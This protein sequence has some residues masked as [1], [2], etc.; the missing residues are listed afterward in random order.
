MHIGTLHL[1][2]RYN[3]AQHNT[4]RFHFGRHIVWFFP[5]GSWRWICGKT[6]L[7]LFVIRVVHGCRLSPCTIMYLATIRMCMRTL[8]PNIPRQSRCR[9]ACQI[10]VLW[11]IFTQEVLAFCS[12]QGAI[13]AF[14][15]TE[16][17]PNATLSLVLLVSGCST[18]CC[19][20][21]PFPISR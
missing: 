15:D 5:G 9:D 14:G 17:M 12:L 2:V 1:A 6:R 10:P 16:H 21:A 11:T 13:Y 4:G 20:G 8:L 18:P 7:A 3:T 19:C